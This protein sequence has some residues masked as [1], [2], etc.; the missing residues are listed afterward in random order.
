MYLDRN[1]EDY[2]LQSR[3]PYNK[4]IKEVSE[5]TEEYINKQF[6]LINLLNYN[7]TD[8]EIFVPDTNALL[9]NPN[10]ENWHFKSVKSFRLV[11]LPTVL[12]ELDKLKIA[13]ANKDIKEKAK[14]IINRIKEYRRRGKLTEGITITNKIHLTALPLEPNFENSLSWLDPKNNDDRIIASLIEVCRKN[15]RNK[16]CFVTTDINL[17]NK[18]EFANLPFIEPPEIE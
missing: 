16:V 7:E 5:K 8:L 14:K 2:L 4:T 18:L 12:S 6:Q 13:H 9:T 3:R 10:I 15:I 17:Q 11:L 1:V